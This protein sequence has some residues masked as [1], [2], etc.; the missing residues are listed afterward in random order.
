[1]DADHFSPTPRALS[2]AVLDALSAL[3]TSGDSGCVKT[4]GRLVDTTAEA[5][6]KALLEGT[7]AVLLHYQ[8][9][10]TS[11]GDSSG[12]VETDAM[13]WQILCIS[14]NYGSRDLRLDDKSSRDPDAALVPGVEQLQDWSR[15]LALR[16]LHDAGATICRTVSGTQAHRIGPTNYIAQVTLRCD[17]EIDFLDDDGA[18]LLAEL[19]IVHD[20]TNGYSDSAQWFEGDNETP[21]SDWPP[22]GVDGGVA[23]L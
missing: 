11:P 1:M 5:I 22:P 9:F 15:Y 3:K 18:N 20:P 17:R 14:S 21:I 8:G 7:P 12:L 13:T 23:T 16:A 19:G 10:Q 2:D 4:V 6:Q